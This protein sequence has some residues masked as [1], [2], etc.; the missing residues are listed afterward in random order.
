MYGEYLEFFPEFFDLIVSINQ[1]FFCKELSEVV[2]GQIMHILHYFMYSCIISQFLD[3]SSNLKAGCKKDAVHDAF[4][5][6][7]APINVKPHYPP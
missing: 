4:D 6:I 1:I 2:S 3:E 5:A 7:Y